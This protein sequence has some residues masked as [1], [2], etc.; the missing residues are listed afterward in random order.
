VAP[1]ASAAVAT[2][3][4]PLRVARIGARG[5]L[6]L[7]VVVT[8]LTAIAGLPL[9]ALVWRSAEAGGQSFWDSVSDPQAVAALKLTLGVSIGVGVINAIV[10]TLIA[11]VL[12]RD[13]FRGKSLV[14][15]VIDLPF[16][17]PT[18]VAGLTLLALYRSASTP[19][20]RA[21]RLCSPCCS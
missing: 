12:V 13:H 18:I 16:A 6:Q 5:W 7:G 1:L 9:A 14:N 8:Y 2:A 10:G 20:T 21:G 15:A 3:A 11:W 19:P 4:P 17:L